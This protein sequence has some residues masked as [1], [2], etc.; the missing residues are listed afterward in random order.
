MY[1]ADA[2]AAGIETDEY[3]QEFAD[4]DR[5]ILDG[6]T[7]GFAKV[8]VRKGTDRILGGTIVAGHAGEMLGELSLA[9]TNGLGLKAIGATIHAYPTQAEALKKL[10][11]AY[12]R[13]RLTPTVAG[14]FEKWLRWIR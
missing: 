4:V 14:L 13:T 8:L 6:D 7:E 1:A 9:I 3:V 10:A 12:S 5:A 2:E 11:D